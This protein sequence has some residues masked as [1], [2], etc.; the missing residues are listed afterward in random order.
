MHTTCPTRDNFSDSTVSV[1]RYR[2]SGVTLQVIWCH[3]TGHLVSR[4]RS[5]GGTLQVI[6]CHVTGHL[7]ARYRSSGVTL[8]VI[9][10]HVT[11]HLL[12]IFKPTGHLVS[13][14]RS[15]ASAFLAYFPKVKV[16]LSNHQS[17]CLTP[18]CQIP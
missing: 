3:V 17:V 16:G 9:W 4:Y 2:S 18:H 15:S 1:L 12:R 13:R 7:V 10:W 5:S 8:Q 6:R 11:G 14:Y